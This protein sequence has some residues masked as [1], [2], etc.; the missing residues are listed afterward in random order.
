MICRTALATIAFRWLT[1]VL[2]TKI[3]EAPEHNILG[4]IFR[5]LSHPNDQSIRFGG[6]QI[7]LRGGIGKPPQ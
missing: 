7:S 3:A 2:S 1:D 6:A 5:R 4:S